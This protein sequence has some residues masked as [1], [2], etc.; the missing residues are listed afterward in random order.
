MSVQMNRKGLG[1]EFDVGAMGAGGVIGFAIAV[2]VPL[3]LAAYVFYGQIITMEFM[4]SVKNDYERAGQPEP[5]EI[6]PIYASNLIVLVLM[7][8]LLLGGVY[9]IGTF[10]VALT[11]GGIYLKVQ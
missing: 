4:S 6:V 8:T 1:V 11:S 7:G 3:A 9:S 10:L 2:G 5:K